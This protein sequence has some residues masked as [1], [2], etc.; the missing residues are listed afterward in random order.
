MSAD[1]QALLHAL[2]SGTR[3]SAADV[4]ATPEENPPAEDNP[5][6]ITLRLSRKFLDRIDAAAK[7]QNISRSAWIKIAI[8]KALDKQEK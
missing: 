7:H 3:K 4:Q 8:S 2:L 1:E 5:Y 6:P